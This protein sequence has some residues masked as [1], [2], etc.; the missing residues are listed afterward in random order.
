MAQDALWIRRDDALVPADPATKAML[1][2]IKRGN[3]ARTN[4]PTQPRNPKF[5]RLMMA[6]LQKVVEQ[7]WP[8]F[9]DTTELMDWLKIRSGMVREV[10][11]VEGVVKLAFK[12]V[13]FAQM[14]E[15]A[16][17]ALSDKWL[18]IICRDLMP[19]TDP[20]GLLN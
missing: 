4:R 9:A 5:H 1:D 6:V 17:K 14:D 15:S 3:Y 12:S 18:E 11:V 20:E 19:G 7:T 2:G 13:S 8:R 16:F 10:Y